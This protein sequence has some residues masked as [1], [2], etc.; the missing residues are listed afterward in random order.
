MGAGSARADLA[1]CRFPDEDGLPLA[2]RARAELDETT[3]FAHALEIAEGRVSAGIVEIGVEQLQDADVR[4]V[5]G[6]GHVAQSGA[7]LL[8]E[9]HGREAEAAALEH[10]AQRAGFDV[11]FLGDGAED[12]KDPARHRNDALAIRPE[13]ADAERPR[14]PRQRPLASAPGLARFPE[15]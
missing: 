9:I 6:G 4:A 15:A 7:L 10:R 12:G 1:A 2:Q 14:L 13:H 8:G 11:D 5:P 3:A